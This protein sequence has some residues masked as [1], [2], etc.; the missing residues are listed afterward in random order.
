MATASMSVQDALWL[1]MDRPNN[2]MVVDGSLVL[3]GTPDIDAVHAIYEDAVKRFPVLGR[4]A[5][6]SG[7][8]WAWED[9]PDFDLASHLKVVD[10]G[11]GKSLVDLQ[12]FMAEQRSQPCPGPTAVGRLPDFPITLDDGTVGSAMMTRFHHSIADGVRLTQVLLGLCETDEASVGAVVARKGVRAARRSHR[13]RRSG[14]WRCTRQA[15]SPRRWRP[16]WRTWP[17]R[18][19]KRCAIRCRP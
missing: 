8:G 5:V 13:P 10:F 4:R 19:C 6:K 7:F 9:D 17:V 11:E 14:A 1:T 2:L 3:R 12:S 15:R 18:R 16:A